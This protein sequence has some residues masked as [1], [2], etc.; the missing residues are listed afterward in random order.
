MEIK[1]TTKT[2]KESTKSI[3]LNDVVWS[4]PYDADLV[5]QAIFVYRSNLRAGSSNAKTRAMVRGGGRKPW[6]QKGT[7]RARHGSIRS[8]LWVGGGVAFP[9]SGK[10]WKKRLNKKMKNKALSMA[11]S[12]RLREGKIKFVDAPDKDLD[13]KVWDSKKRV[14]WVTDNKDVYTKLRNVNGLNLIDSKS[15]NTLNVV[16]YTDI[17]ID[18]GI[19]SNLESRLINE[20]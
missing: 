2:G 19:V 7:G 8:P 9:P 15:L 6:R 1:L 12:Q 14:L 20:K 3:N 4:V 18:S 11:L 10:N 5:A 17:C 13:R 16:S